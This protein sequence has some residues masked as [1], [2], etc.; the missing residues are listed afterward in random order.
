MTG[1]GREELLGLWPWDFVTS[2]SREE[3]LKLI[4]QSERGVPVTV[5]STYRRKAGEKRMMDLRLTR[6]GCPGGD[7]LVASC[8]DLTEQ[9]QFE[10][11]L[12]D[13]D[14]DRLHLAIDTFPG[15]GW[16]GLPDG[17][18]ALG[19]SEHPARDH[20]E[21]L[22]DTLTAVSQESEPEKFVEHILRM[23]GWRLGAHSLGVWEMKC[24]SGRVELVANFEDDRLHLA[25]Q[26]EIR[27]S[28]QVEL[29]TQDHPVWTKFFRG[30]EHC[31][32]GELDSDP[33]RVR[34][35][36][37]PDTPWHNWFGDSVVNPIVQA[38]MKRRFA[39]GI[40]ATLCV[41]MFVGGKVTGMISIRF[42]HKRALRR[43]EMELAR[44]LAHQAM[45]LFN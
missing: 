5:Q 3:I 8:R 22:T 18:E 20:L 6:L 27:A 7:L 36:N 25:T 35:A 42:E 21:A 15:L 14:E 26:E 41:P 40:V 24:N 13:L 9:K 19:A 11:Q 37:G 16:S 23:I 45:L 2:A 31:V 28:R 10:E 4:G 33:P 32:Y 34:M 38:I 43:E 44:A 1:Y 30:G 17:V 39:L 29:A 12:R